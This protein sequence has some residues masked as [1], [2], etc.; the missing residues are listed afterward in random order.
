MGELVSGGAVAFS[1]D[2]RP[3]MSSLLMRRALEYSR[4]FDMSPLSPTP[5]TWT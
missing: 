2:G 5:R 4:M 3:V 1:D